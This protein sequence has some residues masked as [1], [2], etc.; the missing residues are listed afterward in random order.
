METCFNLQMNNTF[1]EDA[2]GLGQNLSCVKDMETLLKEMGKDKQLLSILG[3]KSIR[4]EFDNTNLFCQ[5]LPG[6]TG[7]HATGSSFIGQN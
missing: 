5:I 1:I 7:T 2:W 6:K 4:K 3:K